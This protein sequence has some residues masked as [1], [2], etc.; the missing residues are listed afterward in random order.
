MGNPQL[1]NLYT[2]NPGEISRPASSTPSN[3]LTGN[4][5]AMGA[6]VDLA[7]DGESDIFQRP[8]A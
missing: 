1:E 3:S 6:V 7:L 5:S 8:H 2:G 4:V